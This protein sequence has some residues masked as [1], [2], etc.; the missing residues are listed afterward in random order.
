MKYELDQVGDLFRRME[1][2]EIKLEGIGNFPWIYLEKVN[3]NKV[4]EI[5]LG[6]P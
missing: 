4:K 3:G 1:K 2:M 6:N 5:F